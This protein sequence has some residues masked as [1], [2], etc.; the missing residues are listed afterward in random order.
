MASWVHRTL[1]V[2]LLLA[3]YLFAWTPART[4]WTR[5]TATVLDTTAPAATNVSARAPAHTVSL[6]SATGT[7]FSYTAPAGVKF[8]LPG[9]FLALMIPSRPLLGTF[10]AGHLALGSLAAGLVV[11]DGIGLPGGLSVARF[12]QT[13]GADAYSLSVPVLL[14]VRRRN[15]GGNGVHS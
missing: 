9:F 12:V 14:L 3:A 5:A 10:F 4:A 2:G 8:L 1:L 11:A 6:R 7:S 15:A 13:Y